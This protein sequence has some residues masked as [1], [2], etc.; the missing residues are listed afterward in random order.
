MLVIKMRAQTELVAR[1]LLYK[2]LEAIDGELKTIISKYYQTVAMLLPTEKPTKKDI[3]AFG[4][5]ETTVSLDVLRKRL[6]NVR[7]YS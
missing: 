7:S 3:M 1:K 5:N 6:K 2:K 4:S